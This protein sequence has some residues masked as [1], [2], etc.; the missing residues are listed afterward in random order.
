MISDL[1]DAEAD[2]LTGGRVDS[3]WQGSIMWCVCGAEQTKPASSKVGC[4]LNTTLCSPTARV[5]VIRL[6]RTVKQGQADANIELA[7]AASASARRRR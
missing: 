4:G 5:A 3:Y 7:C 6:L 1:K 2:A